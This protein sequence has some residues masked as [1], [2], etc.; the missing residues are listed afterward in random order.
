M[1]AVMEEARAIG[2]LAKG[3]WRPRRTIV[4]CAWDG[5]EEGLLGSTEWGETHAA[6]LKEHAVAY[7]NS[8]TNGRG[9]LE[10]SGSHSLEKLLNQAGRDV[11]DPQKKISAVD[12]LRA[13]R[14][15]RGSPDEQKDA[16]DRA[17][18]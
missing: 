10:A 6:E 12:R 16:R 1:V 15:T 17:E 7:V 11:T 3:G 4:Y 8:D 14:L 18:L 2:E 9:F 5:E 13:L